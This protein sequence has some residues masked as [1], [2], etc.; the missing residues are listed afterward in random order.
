MQTADGWTTPVAQGWG[1]DRFYLLAAG[2][3]RAEAGRA[4]A[5]LRGVWITAWDSTADRDEFVGAAPRGSIPPGFA[6]I[7]M[8]THGAV[9][10]IGFDDAERE[11][12][13]ARLRS[14]PVPL[15]RHGKPWPL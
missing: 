7:P 4:L 15:T 14:S 12:L 8:G 6:T 3:D 5:E 11:A 2:T 9:V 10:L 1:G 13:A